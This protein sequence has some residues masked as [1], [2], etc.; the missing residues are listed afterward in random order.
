M[1]TGEVYI[2]LKLKMHHWNHH[3]LARHAAEVYMR[4]WGET[5]FI[6]GSDGGPDHR[7]T[8][9]SVQIALIAL[10]RSLKLNLDCLVVCRARTAPY[11]SWKKL[12]KLWVYFELGTSISCSWINV[13]DEIESDEKSESLL[14]KCNSLQLKDIREAIAKTPDLVDASAIYFR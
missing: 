14:S 9:L 5:H 3:L 10:S 11:H 7:A 1:Y 4:W 6:F 12:N 13:H 2:G 8:Y